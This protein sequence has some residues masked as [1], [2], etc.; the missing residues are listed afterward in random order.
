MIGLE[1]YLWVNGGQQW[2]TSTDLLKNFPNNTGRWLTKASHKM[3]IMNKTEIMEIIE[4][5]LAKTF[6]VA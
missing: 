4:P 6:Q 3:K 5:I 2:T 1:L